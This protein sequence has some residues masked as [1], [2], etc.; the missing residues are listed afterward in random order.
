M[1]IFLTLLELH[2]SGLKSILFYPEYQYMLLSSFFA[3]KKTYEKKVD[4][5][6]KSHGLTPLQNVDFFDFARTS[7]FRS[8]KDSLL[9]RISKNVS[10]YLILLK[11]KTY[12]KKV[13]FFDKSHGLTP[14]QNVDFFDFARTSLFRSKKDSLLFRISKNVSFYLIL[15]KKK[16][17]EKKVDFFDKSHGLTPLQN[18]DFFD[19]AR[20]SLF[21]SKK[22]SLLFRISKNVS[23]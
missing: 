13:D 12:E 14:L 7:L 20:T 10:F 6:Y 19:F 2:F 16:T 21:R 9:F 8:K 5:F 15:L 11:K 22:H 3:K 18:V 4:F 1:T 17:Y 23:F